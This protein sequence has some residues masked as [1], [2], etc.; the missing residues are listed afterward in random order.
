MSLRAAQPRSQMLQPQALR[1]RVRCAVLD[2]KVLSQARGS[3]YCEIGDTKVM[4]GV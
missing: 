4:V 3:C 1:Y 2:T